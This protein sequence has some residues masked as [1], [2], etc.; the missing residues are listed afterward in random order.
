MSLPR[1]SVRNSVLVNMLMILVIALGTF[2]LIRLPRELFPQVRLNRVFIA[3]GFPGASPDEVEKLITKP[4]EDAIRRGVDRIDMLLSESVEGR[5]RFSVVFDSID[6]REFRRVYQDLQR[7]VDRVDL[8]SAAEDPFFFSLESSTWMPMANVVISGDLSEARMKLLA[9]DLEDQIASMDGIDDVSVSGLRD[10]EIWVEVDPDRAYRHNLAL[11]QIAAR[12]QRQ[13]VLLPS[14]N[15][16]VGDYEYLVRS[17][18]EF[19]DLDDIAN[20]VIVEDRVGNHVRL[21]DIA[22]IRDTYEEPRALS[23]LNGK[24]AVTLSVYKRPE[25]NSLDLAD[26]LRTLARVSEATLPTGVHI[27]VIG[28]F[29]ERIENAIDR[30]TTSGLYGGTL[31]LFLLLVFLGWRNALFVFWGIPVTFLL[32]FAFIELYGESINEASLF[33]LVLVLGMIVDDAIVVVENITRYLNRGFAPKEAAIR[34][35][36]EVLWPVIS[37]SLTTIAAF[38]PLMLWP[39]TIGD[40]MKVIPICVSFALV[41]SLFESLV[42]LPAHVADLGES[43]FQRRNSRTNRGIRY[44]AARYRR[45]MGPVLRGRWVFLPLIFTAIGA[46]FLVINLVGIDLFEDDEFSVF[47]VR[48]WMPEGSKVLATEAVVRQYQEVAMALPKSEVTS[49]VTM[50]GR[51]D[52][53][54]DRITRK[55]VGQL[56]V[57]LVEPNQRQRSV[58]EILNDMKSRTSN[59][60]GYRRVE[61]AKVNT[62][63]PVG[64]SI[65]VKVRGD[66]LEDLRTI[67]RKLEDY[68][69]GVSGVHSIQNDVQSGKNE[70]RISVDKNRAHLVGLD[71]RDIAR[72]VK[73]AFEGIPATIFRVEDEEVDVVVKFTSEARDSVGDIYDL[74][75]P[76]VTGALI[77]FRQVADFVVEK[78]WT[79][80]NRF[81]GERAITVSADVN[82]EITTPVEVMQNL[83]DHFADIPQQY[84]GYQLD[85]RGEFREFEE[86]FEGITRL[87]LVGVILIY[88]ILGAQFRSF[89]QPALVLFAIPFAFAGAMACLLI[90]GYH[91][92]INVM[93][94][95]V[96]LSGVAVNDTIVLISFINNSRNRGVSL[97]RAILVG[98]KR[99]L[100]PILLTTVTT[101][102]GLLPMSMGWV[103]ESVVWMP[104]AGTIVW[105]LG[106]ATLLILLVIPPLYAAL[107][108]VR[109]LFM[110]RP[111]AEPVPALAYVRA[112][113]R[114]IKQV[115]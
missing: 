42:I 16:E 17:M 4:I 10:R 69:D 6:E 27:D 48:I 75:I 105:G 81:D 59:L 68:L 109:K 90:N 88:L 41:A 60:T 40:W 31:V 35:T 18:E 58:D 85:F 111:K 76:S 36:E 50:I 72:Q 5:C 86:A 34:G 57:H 45:I 115:G 94:G 97:Y 114:R 110:G 80:I 84:P 43:D 24:P 29:S 100:R 83:R 13:N 11:E 47:L 19:S 91:F 12:L 67:G 28:D 87:F 44:M 38:L 56:L 15:I 93:F 70:I 92:S 14:G 74:M 26:Q 99:R 104:L 3:I 98:A 63:P 53:D 8:P 62:G 32:T 79:T 108:D 7:E 95:M 22:T 33:A 89:L 1:F 77:P 102:F 20:V 113:E 107:E 61:F 65:E 49:V 51:L 55:D 106:V 54:T 112:E 46:S 52:T 82:G 73:F 64:R 78:G 25:G 37:S 30:L 9:E 21:G 39:G 2:S 71:S 101:V 23:R 66:N 103:G 96:A